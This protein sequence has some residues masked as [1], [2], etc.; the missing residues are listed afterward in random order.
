MEGNV[1]SS[2][3]QLGR[4]AYSQGL[5]SA[6]RVYRVQASLA[7]ESYDRTLCLTRVS[8]VSGAG[9]AAGHAPRRSRGS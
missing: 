1:V 2:H 3:A 4:G 9:L 5:S 6:F 8:A 7:R